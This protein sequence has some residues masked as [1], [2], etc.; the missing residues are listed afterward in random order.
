MKLSPN[1]QTLSLKDAYNLDYN[2]KTDLIRNDPVTCARYFDYKVN[3]FMWLLRQNQSIFGEY[4]LVDSYE[5]VEFQQRGS[6]HEHILLWLKN[7]PTY[8]QNDDNYDNNGNG[9]DKLINFIDQFLTCKN[10]EENPYCKY[11]IHKHNHSCYKGQTNKQCRFHI[12]YPVMRKTMILTPLNK[13]E[14]APK[15]YKP[16][17]DLIN[18]ISTKG[19][20]MDYAEILKTLNMT[21]TEYIL[22]IRSTLRQNR[23]FLKRSSLEVNI[24]SYNRDIL[25]LFESNIDLQ[26]ILDEYAVVSYVTNYIS[27]IEGGL[28]KLLREAAIDCDNTNKSV[29]EKF[30]KIAN[31]FLNSNLMSAQ[32]AAYHVLSMSLSKQSRKTIFINTGPIAERVLMLKSENDLKKLDRD[33]AEI[34]MNDIFQKY[35]K[36]EKK[37]KIFV[38]LIMQPIIKNQQ[39]NDRNLTMKIMMRVMMKRLNTDNDT[40]QL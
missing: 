28:S 38:S 9:N 6:P 34:Y 36:R 21:E 22:A 3:K 5:R 13:G 31:V 15:S 29:K 19:V 27:K 10:N 33:S 35:S 37:W 40:K 7:P 23:V 8:D 32:E 2:I 12:P 25:Q 1:G 39:K 17:N 18:R 11:Q 20:E 26:F 30:Q 4:V 24:N 14:V 16:V